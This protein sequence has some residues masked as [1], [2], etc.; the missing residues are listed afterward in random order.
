MPIGQAK[1]G[2]LG[3]DIGNLELIETQTGSAVTSILFN[4][5]KEDIY[6]VHF[7]T[8]T[9]YSGT[10][11]NTEARIRF[12]ESGSDY[13]RAHQVGNTSPNFTESKG[14]SDTSAIVC[15]LSDTA[16]NDTANGYNYFYNLGDSSKFSFNTM[17]SSSMRGVH[18]EFR[19]GSG[20]YNVEETINAIQIFSNSGSNFTGTISLYGIR[21]S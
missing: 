2:L 21:N 15:N 20:V 10:V 9:N 19:F 4:D 17:H 14:T 18:Y 12:Y 6:N 13:Q 8:M 11:L 16:T 3:G 5:I 7:M 1:F